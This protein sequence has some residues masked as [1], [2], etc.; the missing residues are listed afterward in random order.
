VVTIGIKG[1]RVVEFMKVPTEKI[2][3]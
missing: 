2:C 3:I 1:I